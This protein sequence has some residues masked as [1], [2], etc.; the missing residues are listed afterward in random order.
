M[1]LKRGKRGM[2]GVREEKREG[3]K[4]EGDAADTWRHLPASSSH[5]P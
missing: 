2:E 4:A 1:E 5:H 3:G